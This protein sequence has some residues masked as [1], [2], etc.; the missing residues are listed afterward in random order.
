MCLPDIVFAVVDGAHQFAGVVAVLATRHFDDEGRGV[1]V[2][3]ALQAQ[4]PQPLHCE[5][6]N[7]LLTL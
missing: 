7:T 4:A 1:V 6:I 3:R 2:R 5:G